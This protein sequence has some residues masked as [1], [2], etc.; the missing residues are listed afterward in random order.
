M[1]VLPLDLERRFEQRWAARFSGV[2][3]GQ[4]R[5]EGQ[6]QHQQLRERFRDVGAPDGTCPRV[7]ETQNQQ[8][9]LNQTALTDATG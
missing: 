8:A 4:H 3:Q 5:L 9:S 7:V 6:Q 1:S 2:Y